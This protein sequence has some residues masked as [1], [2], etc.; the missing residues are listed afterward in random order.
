MH[1]KKHTHKHVSELCEM[2]KDGSDD[3]EM[4]VGPSAM[5][6]KLR[7]KRPGACTL[8]GFTE[9]QPFVSHYFTNEKQ[10]NDH[11]SSFRELLSVGAINEGVDDE[12]ELGK[13]SDD[14]AELQE[15]RDAVDKPGEGSSNSDDKSGVP[16]EEERA[17]LLR[18]AIA[19]VDCCGGRAQPRHTQLH[20]TVHCDEAAVTRWWEK[21]KGDIANEDGVIYIKNA[22]VGRRNKLMKQCMKVLIG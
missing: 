15:E 6:S 10:G 21:D 19:V 16:A 18:V 13:E 12:E 17:N 20:L 9:A 11:A 4:K 22:V 3:K 5:P 2:L 14:E 8:P 7:A 1:G